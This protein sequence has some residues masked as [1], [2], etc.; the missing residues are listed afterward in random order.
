M[1]LTFRI[2]GLRRVHIHRNTSPKRWWRTDLPIRQ[3][4]LW[5]GPVFVRIAPELEGK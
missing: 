4:L 3:T 1:T 5:L 2:P